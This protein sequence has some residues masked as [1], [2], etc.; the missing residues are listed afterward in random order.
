MKNQLIDPEEIY[1]GKPP[2][3]DDST[4][5]AV[6]SFLIAFS[7]IVYVVMSLVDVKNLI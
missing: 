5:I 6:L 3:N 4:L 1:K 2:T 7:F